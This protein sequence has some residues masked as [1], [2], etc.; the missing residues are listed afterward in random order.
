MAQPAIPL[1]R[2]IR[3]L[4]ER[5]DHIGDFFVQLTHWLTGGHRDPATDLITDVRS[6]VTESLEGSSRLA[7][8]IHWGLSAACEVKGSNNMSGTNMGLRSEQ[9]FGQLRQMETEWRVKH[10]LYFIYSWRSGQKVN[11]KV[12]PFLSLEKEIRHDAL[13]LRVALAQR[14]SALFIVDTRLLRAVCEAFGTKRASRE[15]SSHHKHYL[16]INREYL[17]NFCEHTDEGLKELNRG[18]FA[19]SFLP[20]HA[21][22]IRPFRIATVIPI[23]V[24]G[25]TDV[26][27]VSLTVYPITTISM[28]RQL[29]KFL[30][31]TVIAAN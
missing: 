11:G 26:A 12:V 1:E 31:G 5:C 3:E 23:T 9:I 4:D 16:C 8:I 14:T 18:Q 7:D 15:D 21:H 24:A 29:K 28:R 10:H 19:P 25:T 30:N 13:R 27:P 22:R 6:E 20:P 17:R 2:R